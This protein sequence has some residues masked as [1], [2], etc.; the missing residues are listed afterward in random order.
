MD[1]FKTANVAIV[2]ITLLIAVIAAFILGI[3]GNDHAD[4]SREN[5][6]RIC[7]SQHFQWVKDDC[8]YPPRQP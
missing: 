4:K 7:V 6:E 3:R 1:S 5:R 8:L 2:A